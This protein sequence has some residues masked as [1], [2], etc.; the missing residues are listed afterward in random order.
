MDVIFWYFVKEVRTGELR[1]DP[2][3]YETYIGGIGDHLF[4]Y[5][6]EYEIIDWVKENAYWTDLVCE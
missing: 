6:T 4:Y 3:Y 2:L 1:Q 5:G